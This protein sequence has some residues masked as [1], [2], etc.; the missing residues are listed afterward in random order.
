MHVRYIAD[1]DHFERMSTSEIRQSFL[2]DTLF[3]ADAMRMVYCDVDRVI[4]GSVVPMDKPLIL[5]T[6][7]QLRS[8]F[9]C[10][11][12]ELGI[13][14]IGGTGT[15][16]VDGTRYHMSNRDGIYIGRGSR[17]IAFLSV[18]PDE[19]ARFYLLSYPAHTE[20]PTTYIKKDEAEPVHVGTSE[21]SNKRTIYKLIHPDGVQSCQLV[22]GFTEMAA[23]CVWNTMPPHTHERRMEVYMYFDIPQDA[24]VFHFMGKPD[25]TRHIILSNT[26]A[27]IC[28]SWSIHTG[29][30]TAAYSFCWGMGG[31]NQAFDDMDHLSIDQLK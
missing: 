6:A 2:I 31:E 29:V 22:M 12:R 4:V 11:R 26:Q 7:D 28:P 14:N 5:G 10:E 23:G 27:V 25:Q 15:V 9:F 17:E 24:R 20:H 3:K 19:A 13:L 21:Q 30:G 18:N 8:R 16:I 1:P